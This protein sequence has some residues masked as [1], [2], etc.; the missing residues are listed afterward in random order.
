VHRDSDKFNEIINEY[1]KSVFKQARRILGNADAAEEAT[2]EVFIRVYKGLNSFRKDAQLSTWIYRILANVCFDQLKKGPLDF[3]SL[4]EVESEEEMA[5]PDLSPEEQ[6]IEQDMVNRLNNSISKLPPREAIAVT[7]CY[8]DGISYDEIAKVLRASSGT[9]A[10]LLH[11]GRIHL[12]RLLADP[13][14][15]E[16]PK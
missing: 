2:Q 4:D 7:L 5:N 13:T 1:H 8:Y 6:H 15:E 16:K 3:I 10:V 12:H 14:P 11:R 9:V